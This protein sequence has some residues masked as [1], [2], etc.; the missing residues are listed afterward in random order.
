LRRNLETGR[1][2]RSSKLSER[3]SGLL[4]AHERN[5]LSRNLLSLRQ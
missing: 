2:T 1:H 4:A 3:Y 5:C